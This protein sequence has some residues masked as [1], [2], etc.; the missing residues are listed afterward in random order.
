MSWNTMSVQSG[1][2]H[3]NTDTQQNSSHRTI[4]TLQFFAKNI[5]GPIFRIIG[6]QVQSALKR[7]S[8]SGQAC[9]KKGRGSAQT[10]PRCQEC[11]ETRIMFSTKNSNIYYKK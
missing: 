3:H 6:L 1:D 11:G 10:V 8:P 2:T 5:F 9:K 4:K 7:K